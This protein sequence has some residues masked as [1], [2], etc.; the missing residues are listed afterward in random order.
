MVPPALEHRPYIPVGSIPAG[1]PV[2]CRKLDE[3]RRTGLR[4]SS[5]RDRSN[6][7]VS[8]GGKG[9]A[10]WARPWFGVGPPPRCG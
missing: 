2:G 10:T 5:G 8:T 3:S 6:P 7:P 4:S 1:G 9:P